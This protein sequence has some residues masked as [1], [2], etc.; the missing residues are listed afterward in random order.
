MSRK[1]INNWLTY[2]RDMTK[3]ELESL[4]DDFSKMIL[5]L[6]PE[7]GG[8]RKDDRLYLIRKVKMESPTSY[9][10]WE[11]FNT[12]KELNNSDIHKLKLRL[13]QN[14]EYS[15]IITY[16][17]SNY[18]IKIDEAKF[19][20][21]SI[22]YKIIFDTSAE[23]DLAKY[24]LNKYFKYIKEWVEKVPPDSRVKLWIKGIK[25]DVEV[26]S[27]DYNIM[28]RQIKNQDFEIE[29]PF[30]GVL[31]QQR[32]LIRPSLSTIIL[33]LNC[34][35]Y[36]NEIEK[37]ID[38]IMT[39][40]RLFKLGS[41]YIEKGEYYQE[42]PPWLPRTISN[43]NFRDRYNYI[44]T[45]EDI[46]KIQKLYRI[47]QSNL[48]IISNPKS[49]IHIAFQRYTDVLINGGNV[50]SDITTTINCLEAL[51]LNEND[52]LSRRL[53][54]R[55]SGIIRFFDV[56]SKKVYGD[57][58]TAYNVRSKYIHGQVINEKRRKEIRD[59]Q[60]AK[61]I[62]DYARI[63]ILVFI[64]LNSWKNK[65]DLIQIIDNSLLDLE[66]YK[67]LKEK[68]EECICFEN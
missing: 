10:S 45:S 62:L 14:E 33:E 52:E 22:I 17:T 23:E 60:L 20:L 57:I 63:S 2:G 58:K 40:L 41:V 44:I 26:H 39:L 15:E 54:Q 7:V 68:I 19:L 30:H 47:I 42:I 59:M 66:D 32:Y 56:E 3:Q 29:I 53:S 43:G 49:P 37:D 8:I 5:D 38:L 36:L 35:K 25:L 31:M 18:S 64:Q 55:V 48:S 51:Y 21:D 34:K 16:I 4:W 12:K 6:I 65:D 13:K 24:D 28:I 9:A 50:E 46:P 67:E 1:C 11:E 61:H 27:I